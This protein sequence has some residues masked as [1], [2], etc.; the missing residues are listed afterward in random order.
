MLKKILFQTH[1]LLGIT[2]GVVL[3]I[4]G[5]TGALLSFEGPIQAWLNREV[6]TVET[7]ATPALPLD[8]LAAEARRQM[9]E[10]RLVSL[11]LSASPTDSVR[12]T[13]APNAPPAPDASAARGGGGRGAAPTQTR[14]LDPYTGTLIAGA[15]TRGQEFFRGTR[16]L[17]RWLTVGGVGNQAVGKQ[18][19]GASTVFC[20]V[21]VLS[22]LYLRWPRRWSQW[23]SWLALNW[24]LKGRSFLWHLHAVLGTWVL[25]FFLVMSLTG[26]Y[27]SYDWYRSGLFAL[28]G[29]EQ[30]APRG[31]ARPAEGKPGEAK[32]AAPDVDL[33]AVWATF[34]RESATEPYATATVTLPQEAGRPVEVRY[35]PLDAPHDRASNTLS[36]D[37]AGAAVVKHERYRAKRPGERFMA[38]I[39]P[40]HSGSFF[41]LP[42]LILFMLASLAMPVFT[43]TGWMLY[44]DRRKKKRAANAARDALPGTASTAGDAVL[45]V[46]A[47]QTGTAR[48]IAWQTAR[49]LRAA[50]VPAEVA[51]ANK[52]APA[53]LAAAPQALFVVSTFGDGEPPDEARLFERQLEREPT[54]MADLRYAVLALGDRRYDTYCLFG[55][56]LDDALAARGATSMFPRVEM[57]NADAEAL[58]E[59][60][61]QLGRLAPGAIAVVPDAPSF[62]A[63]RLAAR[64]PLNPGSAG[65]PT[66]HIELVPPAGATWEAGDI[67]VVQP[68]AAESPAVPARRAAVALAGADAEEDVG[69]PAVAAAAPT[70]VAATSLPLREFSIASVPADGRLHLVVRQV[71][72]GDGS[73]GIGSGWLTRHAALGGAISLRVRANP[74]FR[75]PLDERPLI[76]IGNGTGIAGL[77]ALLKARAEA[78]C[79]RNWLLF[80]ERNAAHDAYYREEL[81]DLRADG[82]LEH[83]DWAFSRD[84][85]SKVYVQDVLRRHAERLREWIAAG[86]VLCICG[87][88]ETM[89]P[90]VEAVL[91]DVL[92][93]DAL[94]QLIE[95]DRYRRDV[96]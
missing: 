59:W 96:Y 45:V 44:L 74:G 12:A 64:T 75:A 25:P 48:E 26:L 52:V 2:A 79:R 10:H 5:A 36:V 38:S 80:G 16:S 46:H 42:G 61:A 24:Q 66:Y 78:G 1:W 68:Q 43:V 71:R 63:W 29:V 73:F 7:R 93:E 37:A 3:G 30:P 47:S 54:P 18:I 17:H 81:D 83:L 9:P 58:A 34:A 69:A 89:A 77:R 87:S 28:A 56:R 92:G 67:A 82:F 19:V 35:I 84:Q 57:D 88:A 33:A 20:V 65:D 40:L 11:A 72:R 95:E 4:V 86:A 32:P 91:T 60:N 53:Q 51:A 55:R 94:R 31:G 21:L 50:G 39:F 15:G 62:G 22:G 13:F 14:Y 23:R 41:G 70:D 27:W 8:Q 76:L 90:A 49:V 85:A 6:R